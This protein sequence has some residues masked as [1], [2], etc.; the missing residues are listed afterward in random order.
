MASR[1]YLWEK[2]M[3][4]VSCLCGGGSFEDRLHNAYI[5][6]L[7]R[8]RVD[9][10]PKTLSDDLRWVLT[11]CQDNALPE[12]RGMRKIGELDRKKLIDTLIHLLAETS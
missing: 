7:M 9:D 12:G 10:A 6:A 3:V 11:F 8:L 1:D 5:S 2:I 4:A